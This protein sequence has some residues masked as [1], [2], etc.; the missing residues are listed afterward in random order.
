ML[1]RQKPAVIDNICKTFHLSNGERNH[2]LT[3]G[4][5]EGLLIMEDEHSE[6]KVIASPEEHRLITTNA[7]E[8]NETR[9]RNKDLPS[10]DVKINVDENKRFFRKSK[11]SKDEIKYLLSKGYQEAIFNSLVTN[12]KEIF[13]LQPRSNES[14]THL[15]VVYDIA[16]YLE[17]KGYQVE[18][19][20]TK[21]PDIVFKKGDKTF[22]IE[23]ET[24]GKIQ[25]DLRMIK[26]KVENLNKE[27]KNKWFFVVTDRNKIKDYK[28]FGKSVDIRY[29]KLH[30]AELLR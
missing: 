27:Y 3:A 19:Y 1:M 14:L 22:A 10:K 25:K 4:I 6:I 30:L 18:K 17:K 21:K 11:L 5:G 20:A 13:L 9:S 2:L 7:D 15:F 28:K 16:E 24:G 26:E 8:L 12:K 23:V 29:L